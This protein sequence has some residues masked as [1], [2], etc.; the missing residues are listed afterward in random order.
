MGSYGFIN[1]KNEGLSLDDILGSDC[2]EPIFMVNPLVLRFCLWFLSS[3]DF[4]FLHRDDCYDKLTSYVAKRIDCNVL[5]PV[6]IRST[7]PAIN[8]LPDKSYDYSTIGFFHDT[9]KKM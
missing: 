2:E 7:Y 4:D 3:S 9:L 1:K 8:M 5:K 6:E